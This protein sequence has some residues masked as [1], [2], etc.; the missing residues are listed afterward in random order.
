MI[1]HFGRGAA[2]ARALQE[3]RQIA[4]ETTEDLGRLTGVCELCGH[5]HSWPDARMTC[6]GCGEIRCHGRCRCEE[7]GT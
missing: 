7:G 3:R 5:A 6:V 2:R 1:R 4:G